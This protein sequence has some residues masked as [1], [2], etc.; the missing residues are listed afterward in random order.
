MEGAVSDPFTDFMTG[1]MSEKLIRFERWFY[2]F[3]YV[4][5]AG[6][7]LALAAVMAFT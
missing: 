2:G 1:Q 7:V 3:L 5:L 4:A 6:G